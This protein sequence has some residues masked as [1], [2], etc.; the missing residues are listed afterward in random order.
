M[1]SRRDP[2]NDFYNYACGGWLAS[3]SIPSTSEIASRMYQGGEMADRNNAVLE[4]ILN[5][6]K[7]PHLTEYY[8]KCMDED[9]IESS[10]INEVETLLGRVVS[11]SDSLDYT[12]RKTSDNTENLFY[13]KLAD[14]HSLGVPA[15]FDI[16]IST[17]AE[18]QPWMAKGK[19]MASKD[20]FSTESSAISLPRPEYYTEARWSDTLSKFQDHVESMFQIYVEEGGRWLTRYVWTLRWSRACGTVRKEVGCKYARIL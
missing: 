6:Q 10:G 16:G 9:Q 7:W 12:D 18:G 5:N 15:F 4:D 20:E 11:M 19:I 13:A 3:S 2:C 8:D 17:D 14:M 1:D